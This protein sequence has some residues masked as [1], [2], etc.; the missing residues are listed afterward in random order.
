MSG[1]ED[2]WKM[3]R[4]ET[5][6]ELHNKEPQTGFCLLNVEIIQIHR[7][8]SLWNENSNRIPSQRD[9]CAP[10]FSHQHWVCLLTTGSWLSLQEK[11]HRL[12]LLSLIHLLAQIVIDFFFFWTCSPSA[13][14]M[15]IDFMGQISKYW[16]MVMYMHAIKLPTQSSSDTWV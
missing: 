15:F 8:I 13:C 1:E 5:G 9:A 6:L 10:D 4:R 3:I 16:L 11:A 14:K 2:K 7:E 12:L